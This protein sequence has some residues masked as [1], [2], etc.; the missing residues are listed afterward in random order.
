[1]IA[2]VF[3]CFLAARERRVQKETYTVSGQSIKE[4]LQGIKQK[5]G[6]FLGD[7]VFMDKQPWGQ[8]IGRFLA[9][10]DG[11]NMV[12]CGKKAKKGFSHHP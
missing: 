11:P 4:F 8:V 1:L 10:K 5:N 6:V 7:A 12:T 3:T 2:Y 9:P